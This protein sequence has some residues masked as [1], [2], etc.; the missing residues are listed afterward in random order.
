[1]SARERKHKRI[2]ERGFDS[3]VNSE[4]TRRIALSLGDKLLRCHPQP[5]FTTGDRIDA[6]PLAAALCRNQR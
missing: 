4:A 5:C 2:G 6:A 3:P 1:M